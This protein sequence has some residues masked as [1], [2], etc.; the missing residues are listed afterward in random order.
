MKGCTVDENEQEFQDATHP[1]NVASDRPQTF[2]EVA[3]RIDAM[4][5][6]PGPLPGDDEENWVPSTSNHPAP[7]NDPYGW[8]AAQEDDGRVTVESSTGEQV[9]VLP[10]HV[11]IWAIG[12]PGPDRFDHAVAEVLANGTLLVRRQGSTVPLKGYAAGVWQTFEHV[13]AVQAADKWLAD[14]QAMAARPKKWD[15]GVAHGDGPVVPDVPPLNQLLTDPL[16]RQPP[17]LEQDA[18]EVDPSIAAAQ[19]AFDRAKSEYYRK[20]SQS[21]DTAQLP[22]V[23]SDD[24]ADG[25]GGGVQAP[26]APRVRSD[27][28]GTAL[29]PRPESDPADEGGEE[30]TSRFPRL[31]GLW[32]DLMSPEWAED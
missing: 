7:D 11:E 25:E 32:R 29:T 8:I 6:S 1:E 19:S 12:F 27:A 9:P 21:H 15:L 22:K 10:P 30:K 16:R 28:P 17:T 24:V 18:D 3:A 2:E 13:G 20:R 5:M 23:Q 14:Q 31:R 26:K 4:P